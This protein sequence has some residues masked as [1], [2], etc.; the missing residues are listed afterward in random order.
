MAAAQGAGP[1][2]GGRG[3]LG[4]EVVGGA[5]DLLERVEHGRIREGGAGG[6][7]GA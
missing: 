4:E 7:K 1:V 5:G 6:G 3:A 2:G